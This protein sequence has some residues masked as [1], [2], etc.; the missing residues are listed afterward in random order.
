MK[1]FTGDAAMA[2]PVETSS[3][4]EPNARPTRDRHFMEHLMTGEWTA[5]SPAGPRSLAPRAGRRQRDRARDDLVQR[6]HAV[7]ELA[8]RAARVEPAVEPPQAVALGRPAR[9]VEPD[10]RERAGGGHGLV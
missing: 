3:A 7:A 5:G 4:S 2:Q 9:A 6:A 1:P 8:L 10:E